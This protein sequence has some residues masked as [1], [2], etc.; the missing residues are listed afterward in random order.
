MI[1]KILI[2]TL[3]FSLSIEFAAHSQ[4]QLGPNTMPDVGSQIP[5]SPNAASLGKYG[6]TPVSYY[7]G[8]PNISVP[9]FQIKSG[10]LGL[11]ISLSYHA[12]GVKV[13]EI[14]SWV[15]LGWS[16]NAGGTITRQLRGLPDEGNGGYLQYYSQLSQYLNQTMSLDDQAT[17]FRQVEAGTRDTQ[18][19]IFFFNLG[20]QTGKFILD[21]T[22]KA[23]PIPNSRLKIELGNYMGQTACWKVTDL[24]GNQYFLCN[25]E[26]SQAV[27]NGNG[28]LSPLGSSPVVN[29]WY[30]SKILNPLGTDSI[31]FNYEFSI[32]HMNSS[33]SQTEY[34]L[35]NSS[36]DCENKPTDSKY[37]TSTITGWR[38]SQIVFNN[39]VVNLIRNQQGRCD[40]P[41][42]FA[43][44]AI[45]IKNTRGT[46]DKIFTLYQ[47]YSYSSGST[48]D[49]THPEYARLFLDS[50]RFADAS[51][52]DTGKYLFKYKSRNL[53]SRLSYS[54]DHWGFYNGAA[55]SQFVPSVNI[56]NGS[57]FTILQG[58][59]RSV[60][61]NDAQAGILQSIT[62]PT[63]GRTQFL[64]ENNTIQK[65]PYTPLFFQ[66]TKVTPMGFVVLPPGDGRKIWDTTLVLT[67]AINATA[68]IFNGGGICAKQASLGCP[69]AGFTGP[70][71]SGNVL[72]T[73]QFYMPAGT[74]TIHCNLSTVTDTTLL[75][76]FIFDITWQVTQLDVDSL[77]HNLTVGGLRIK[78]MSDFT[79]DNVETNIRQYQYLLPD[80][81]NYSSGFSLGFPE[82]S[83]SMTLN[84]Y[85]HAVTT[86]CTYYTFSS[87]SN[88]PLEATQGSYTGYKYVTELLGNNGEFGKNVYQFRA[89]DEVVDFLDVN[90][91]YAPAETREWE[92]GQTMHIKNYRYDA[93]SNSYQLVQEKGSGYNF[94]TSDI[95]LG[96]KVARIQFFGPFTV[97]GLD[98]GDFAVSSYGTEIG[99][100]PLISDTTILY[101]QNSP[102]NTLQKVTSN[103]YSDIHFQPITSSTTLSTG[104]TET[105][106]M[107]Y[108]LDFTGLAGSDGLSQGIQALQQANIVSPVIEKFTQRKAAN[109][110]I[111]GTTNSILT[112]YNA[113]S[114]KPDTIWATEYTQP[115]LSFSSLTVSGGI[116]SKDPAYVAQVA[117]TRY[118]LHGNIVQQHKVHDVQ[119]TYLWDY[120]GE[121]P[122]ASA[123]N[124]DS[125]DIAYSSFEADGGGNWT[126]GSGTI[127]SNGGFTGHNSYNLTGNITK[128]G[129]S[130]IATYIVSYWSQGG[131]MS[132]NGTI[133]GY[134]QKGKTI[135]INNISWTL[136][137]HKVTGQSTITI[138]GSG[139]I[140]ELRLYPASAQM[141]TYTYDP[142]TGMTSQTDVANRT[143]YY[144]YDGLA[145]LKRIRDQDYNILKTFDYQYQTPAGCG[146]GCSIVSMQTAM[147][148][149]TISYPVGVFNIHGNLLGNAMNAGD[150][151]AKWNSDTA[152]NRIGTLVKG[153]DSM[154]FNLT[155]NTGQTPPT[156][157][158]G[159]RYYQWDLPWN[160]LDGIMTNSGA[161]VDFGDG[162]GMQV[163][164]SGDSTSVVFAPNTTFPYGYTVHSY[165]DTS[166]KTITI[167]HNDGNENIGLDNAN[168]PATS[169]TK[170]RH[171]RG[172]F[173]QRATWGKFSSMQQPSALTFD[174]IY[175]WNSITTIASLQIASGDGGVTPCTN[176]SFAQD[177]MAGNRGLQ[178]IETS[179]T[180]YHQSGIRDTT[181]KLSL[182]K[183]DWNTYFTNLQVI[184]ISDDHWNREDLSALT[185][186]NIFFLAATT[187]G[188]TNDLNSLPVP[189]PDSVVDNILIQIAAG[190][191]Q[192]VSN[193]IIYINAVGPRSSASNAAVNF[194]LSKGWSVTI[195]GKKQSIQ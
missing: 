187:I 2:N 65:L 30:L 80:S 156:G 168:S 28:A 90:P 60:N 1:G 159:C 18:Q 105:A 103:T 169:L 176:V 146:S 128:S 46:F 151:V 115:S 166:L 170:V 175:N 194:L 44:S 171:L 165:P 85:I 50:I 149:A 63:G 173:P 13:E 16:L 55:N 8:I 111:I 182:L 38:L 68:S 98:P 179:W 59:D 183:S 150:F 102:G 131:A 69:L 99:W 21:S 74:Y 51:G 157:V 178:T 67:Y 126:Y 62:Y 153:A 34:Y 82:Y 125:N 142:L 43:L 40:Y 106:H 93:G 118:D 121:F 94:A 100:T 167:Y 143:T 22:G 191:G 14:A 109:G 31:V 56:P 190:A 24:S 192:N 195:S 162:T 78:R 101:D 53:P 124:A 185:K 70:V 35:Y 25:K 147:G 32:T 76:E 86:P 123:T 104:E 29:T 117:N 119:H 141:T 27:P 72:T 108:P 6:E 9:I 136:Y 148:T 97:D 144:E 5:I 17:Y 66:Q 158:T 135:V 10:S 163:P 64:F 92:R 114:L 184:G 172:Y 42:D 81:A 95:Y 49:T 155:L 3:L 112:K 181:F 89:P 12:G 15:G 122:V 133:S 88:Y 120:L 4:Q 47:S 54:Q 113:Y 180:G 193:G 138:S 116:L 7:T 71:S 110:T 140:D 130:T 48:C 19:D 137:I 58:A 77:Q 127:N 33:V 152:D 11:P 87:S 23:L 83:G 79:A 188:H 91:P 177:F 161:Y 20:G 45:E 134:P 41:S 57:S 107:A 160:I 129:L 52:I 145:R 37:V 154:H 174:S 26:L 84:Q 61:T 164:K 186:L 36:Q 73:S 189:I 132:I 39:G 75:K 96:I 139:T